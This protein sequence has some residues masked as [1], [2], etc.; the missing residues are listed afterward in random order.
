MLNY[1]SLRQERDFLTTN[2]SLYDV[3]FNQKLFMSCKG[4]GAPTVILDAPTGQSSDC[5]NP[6][7]AWLSQLTKVCV[8]D[9]AGLGWSHSPPALNLSDPGEAAVARTLGKEGTVVR[10]VSDLH[11]LV[12][13]SYPQQKPFILVGSE[14]GALVARMYS[15]LHTNDVAHLVMI[16]PLSETLFD[17]V[18]NKNDLEK[19]ENPWLSYMFGAVLMNLRLLQVAAMTG[20]ARLGL[21]TGL[22]KTPVSEDVKQKHLLCDPFHLQA[23]IDEHL[24][25]AASL[26]QM[27]EVSQ[28]WPLS[29]INLSSTVMTGSQYDRHLPHQLNMGWSRA[30]QDVIEKLGSKHHVISGADRTDL[31]RSDLVKE[32]LAPVARIVSSSRSEQS[33]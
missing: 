19:T 20:L 23:V 7:V 16:D 11:R 12:T 21:L 9:R 15:H 25:L 5:W 27:K 30:V 2:V 3:G 13:F 17:D 18:S 29:N 6:G 4:E 33:L 28:A 14:L 24:G 31:L 10:M 1:A 32:V 8:Y 22:M 26:E